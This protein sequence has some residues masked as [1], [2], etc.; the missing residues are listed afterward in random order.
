MWVHNRFLQQQT[1]TIIYEN[2]QLM[3]SGLKSYESPMLI[4]TGARFA[5]VDRNRYVDKDK[6]S[7]R[8]Q[9]DILTVQF[10]WDEINKF[11]K[12]NIESIDPGRIRLIYRGTEFRAIE[13]NDHG[14]PYNRTN[15]PIGLLEIKFERKIPVDN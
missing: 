14:Q 12:K 11:T 6:D 13:V 8:E 15:M 9:H 4:Q 2:D 5:V 1:G 10:G 7:Q 3:V